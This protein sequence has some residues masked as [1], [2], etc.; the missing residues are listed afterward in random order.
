[1]IQNYPIT[2]GGPLEPAPKRGFLGLGRR[3]RDGSEVPKADAHQV[4]VY[5]VDG[6]YLVD[7]GRLGSSD[8][9]VVNAT[10]VSVVDM[11]R[12]AQ[13]VVE[14]PIPSRDASDFMMRVTF[15]CTVTDPLVVVREGINAAS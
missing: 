8:E 15:A 10:H 2:G 6:D 13:V 7:R 4:L 9:Q 5:R 14:L 1:M 12:S 3:Y 11:R